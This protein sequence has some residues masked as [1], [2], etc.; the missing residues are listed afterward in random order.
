MAF[1]EPV[2]LGGAGMLGGAPNEPGADIG[3]PGFG[4]GLGPG[5]GLGLG[6]PKGGGGGG[7][8][9]APNGRSD[10]VKD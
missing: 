2:Q 3:A 8:G 9:D 7:E 10:I 1:S 4:L 6:P 5:F